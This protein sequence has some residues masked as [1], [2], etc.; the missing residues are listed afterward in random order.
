MLFYYYIRFY[1]KQPFKNALEINARIYR[2]QHAEDPIN[3]SWT[4][5]SLQVDESTNHL[6]IVES[7]REWLD[8]ASKQYGTFYTQNINFPLSRSLS[9][10]Y[11]YR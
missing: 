8:G 1:L 5:L 11:R 4:N 10:L 7:R 2:R 3:D 9:R 6:V